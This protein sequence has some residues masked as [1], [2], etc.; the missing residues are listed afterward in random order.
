MAS[1]SVVICGAG[2]AGVEGLLRLRRLAG[3]RVDVTLVSPAEDFGYRP[4][5]VLEPFTGQPARRYPVARIAA[6]TGAHWVRD[7]LAWLDRDHRV[8]HTTEGR[9]LGYDALLLAIG[10]AERAPSPHVDVFAGRDQ[11]YRRI[12]DEV[13]AGNVKQLA[14]VLP[15]GPV[16][17]LPLY[18]LA[19]LTAAR[20]RSTGRS[21]QL[22]LVIPGPRPLA[23]FGGDAGDVMTRLLSEAGITLHVNSQAA[24]PSPHRIVLRPGETVLGPDRIVSLPTIGGPSVRGIPGFALDR[25]LHVD[26]YCRVLDTDGRI[27]AAGDATDLPV[28]HGGVGAQQ[29]DTAA[30]GIAHLAG[31]GP[32]PERLRPRIEAVLM[33]GDKPLYLSAYLIDGTG[34]RANIQSEPPWPTG[35]KV[36]AEELGAFLPAI[37]TAAS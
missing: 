24:I 6:D 32:A 18:E 19:L 20:G 10:G 2:I 33:T 36:V 29:A 1:F 8:V 23:A 14:F 37:D 30:A 7:S 26:E 5:S 22:D 34:W 21:L 27:Y 31:A 12:L 25:F 35:Q 11:R 15:P 3:D 9:P 17:P 28:K 13:D 16:W 4:L